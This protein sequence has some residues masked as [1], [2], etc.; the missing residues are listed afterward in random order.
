[1]DKARLAETLLRVAVSRERA[2][3]LVGDLLEARPKPGRFW[4]AVG[5]LILAFAWRPLLL[6]F[7]AFA[8]AMAI[9]AQV[10]TAH[11]KLFPPIAIYDLGQTAPSM[12]RYQCSLCF[13]LWFLASFTL[14][15]FGWEL[16]TRVVLAAAFG[17]SCV[18]LSIPYRNSFIGLTL[19]TCIALFYAAVSRRGRRV[20]AVISAVVSIT[21][22]VGYC[23]ILINEQIDS[24]NFLPGAIF[25][26]LS[27]PFVQ[28]VTATY[29]RRR[30]L[31]MTSVDP[32]PLTTG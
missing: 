4:P 26:L 12:F 10:F 18:L 30:F 29:L 19:L 23:F 5:L 7:I 22:F 32:K 3:E 1:M 2:S 17:E 8:S 27:L 31:S 15:R 16:L 24:S 20:L 25:C 11:F 28:G 6:S 14:L 9:S 13:F 21:W